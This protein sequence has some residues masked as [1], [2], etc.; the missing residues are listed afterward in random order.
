MDYVEKDMVVLAKADNPKIIAGLCIH[1]Q[2]S[3]K[4]EIFAAYLGTISVKNN[5]GP[6]GCIPWSTNTLVFEGH[7]QDG[8]TMIDFEFQWPG[9]PA[10][11][12]GTAPGP[13]APNFCLRRSFPDPVMYWGDVVNR[14]KAWQV[15]LYPL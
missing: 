13:F 15:A 7:T 9:K 5:L 10:R 14:M 3:N 6:D 2:D 4:A 1:D 12:V 11:P 8:R